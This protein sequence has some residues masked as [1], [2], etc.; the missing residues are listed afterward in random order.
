MRLN[1]GQN[2]TRGFYRDAGTLVASD[3]V[4]PAGAAALHSCRRVTLKL[5]AHM[6][7]VVRPMARSSAQPSP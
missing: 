3:S 7:R 2:V 5:T 4:R 6:G 1:S